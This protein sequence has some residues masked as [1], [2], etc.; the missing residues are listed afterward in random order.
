MG[1][2]AS[3]PASGDAVASQGANFT[4]I[5]GTGDLNAIE[6]HSD[7]LTPGYGEPEA[8]SP[9]QAA[10]LGSKTTSMQGGASKA[11]SAGAK[12]PDPV[13]NE[14][15]LAA[16]EAKSDIKDQK[17]P[18]GK[19]GDMTAMDKVGRFWKG[20]VA[21]G[22]VDDMPSVHAGMDGDENAAGPKTTVRE[23]TKVKNKESMGQPQETPY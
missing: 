7:V 22:R 20:K 6:Q 9:E 23:T 19:T 15:D 14:P 8:G 10:E 4:E 11:S 5:T 1:A 17:L 2:S 16:A 12:D 21:K 13:L 3:S 18:A